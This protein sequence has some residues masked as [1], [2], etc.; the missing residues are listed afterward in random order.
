[1]KGYKVF[2]TNNNGELLSCF[3]AGKAR[4]KYAKEKRSKAPA[5]LRQYNKH[6]T[7][8][9]TLQ[10]ALRFKAGYLELQSTQIWRVRAHDIIFGGFLP[11]KSNISS[12]GKGVVQ[13]TSGRWPLGTK[14]ARTIIPEEKIDRN[15]IRRLGLPKV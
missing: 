11:S 2:K 1:M 10:Q 6:L 4:V 14:M 9:L 7:F 12:L 3:V 15:E 8:F 13:E 5:W